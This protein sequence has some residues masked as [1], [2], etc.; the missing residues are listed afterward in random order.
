MYDKRKRYRLVISLLLTLFLLF[1]TSLAC[2]DIISEKPAIN[3]DKRTVKTI[4]HKRDKDMLGV[5]IPFIESKNLLEFE[6]SLGE[7]KDLGIDTLIV[8]VFQNKGDR[9]HRL[10]KN[11]RRTGIYFKSRAAPVLEDI[12][13]DLVRIAH[14]NNMKIYAWMS[15]RSCD[16]LISENKG[17]SDYYYDFNQ[18]KILRSHKLNLFK[19]EAKDYLK[20]LYVDLARYDIDGILLQDDLIMKHNESFSP[21]AKVEFL[22]KFGYNLLP[23]KMYKEIHRDY[24][25]KI[26]KYSYRDKFWTWT[27]WKSHTIVSFLQDL[28][29][30]TKK[31]NP[32]LK[33][34][35]N[36]YYETISDPENAKAWLSQDLE[37]IKGLNLDYYSFMFYHRQIRKEL[38][39]SHHELKEFL[40]N[41]TKR[42]ID[43]IGDP[44][45]S[46]FKIQV[47]DW[48]NKSKIS[49]E[50][51]SNII[52]VLRS[53]GAG[54][55]IFF[56]EIKKEELD[57]L[58]KIL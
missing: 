52:S 30:S 36:L 56:P 45:K 46:I 24:R 32:K 47:F 39:L 25:G 27:D 40:K 26:D 22:K 20:R 34:I 18:R 58:N 28:I 37:K 15:T 54:N 44:K 50:E 53:S 4:S 42:A 31:I 11:K 51:I 1:P 23:D 16:W 9:N 57:H 10:V 21:E 12:L 29:F 19:N 14:K 6:R 43:R 8:R 35:I 3:R 2:K 33:F 48:D 5:Q 13:Q 41:L 49:S 55:F 17:L 38:K 7:L